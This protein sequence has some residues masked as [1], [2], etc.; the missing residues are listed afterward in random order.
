MHTAMER[1]AI[2]WNARRVGSGRP[3]VTTTMAVDMAVKIGP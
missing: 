2:P 1:A 3:S